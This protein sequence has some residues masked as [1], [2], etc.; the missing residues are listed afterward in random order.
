[1]DEFAAR[2][3]RGLHLLRGRPGANERLTNGVAGR[4]RCEEGVLHFVK[5]L[6][7]LELPRFDVDVGAARNASPR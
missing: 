3:I 5:A 4:F 2:A 1:M 6:L 7:E